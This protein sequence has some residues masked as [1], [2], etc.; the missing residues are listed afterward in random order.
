MSCRRQAG[1]KRGITILCKKTPEFQDK[2]PVFGEGPHPCDLMIIGEAPGRQETILGKPFVGR[3]GRFFISL[4]EEVLR[5]PRESIY[6]T[7]VV[8]VWTKV[9]TP[10]GRTRPPTKT[11]IARFIPFL[12]KEIALVNPVII[13]AVGRTAF[14]ALLPD[15]DFIPGRW[16]NT[17]EGYR[18]IPVYHPAY[19]LRRQDRLE[20]LRDELVRILKKIR[21]SLP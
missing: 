13:M 18:I 16:Y 7:N 17:T 10:R 1:I 9:D 12:K 2:T 8:K 19:I 20:E 15:G 21:R 6:I 4:I 5:R 3:T 11:E 14:S